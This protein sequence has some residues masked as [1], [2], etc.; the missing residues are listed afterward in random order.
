VA[1]K[2]ASIRKMIKNPYAALAA[3]LAKPKSRY[4]Q[5]M[6]LPIKWKNIQLT[7]L[8]GCTISKVKSKN[9]KLFAKLKANR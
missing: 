9:I 1:E 6:V 8:E 2:K 7:Y 3:R 4:M 5:L